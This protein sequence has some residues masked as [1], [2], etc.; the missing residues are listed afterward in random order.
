M[1]YLEEWSLL[2]REYTDSLSGI[3]EALT[4]SILCLPVTDGA[5]VV[6]RTPYTKLFPHV[7]CIK[8]QVL[9]YF[10]FAG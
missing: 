6:I 9:C 1:A 3:V 10:V 8:A 5:K 2:E 4:A 7:L